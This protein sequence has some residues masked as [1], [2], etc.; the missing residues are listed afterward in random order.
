M[1][2]LI[3]VLAITGLF[4]A[5]VGGA[6][7]AKRVALVIGNGAYQHSPELVNPANDAKIMAG[8]LSKLGFD[9]V[10]ITDGDHKAILDGMSEFGRR[11][12]GADTALFFYAG[13]GLEVAGRNWL[14]PVDADIQASSDLPST[15]VK[16]DDVI[17]LMEL[18]DAR[19][20]LIVL[21]ACRN[22]PLPRSISRSAKR[23]LAK[24]DASAAGTM[25]VFSAA[26][27]EVALDGSGA[28][29]PFSTAL[30]KRIL[31]PGLE[32]RQMVGRVRQDVLAATGDKQVPWVNEAISG[33]FYLAGKPDLGTTDSNPSAPPVA[34]TPPQ[35]DP[36]TGELSVELAFWDSVK[37]SGNKDLI[38]LY[39]K[40]YPNGSFKDLAEVLI[41]SIDNANSTQRNT[42]T[43][44]PAAPPAPTPQVDQTAQMEQMSRQFVH[45]LNA[46]LSMPANQAVN[47][48]YSL[49]APNV[50][51]YGKQFS[52][53]GIVKDK[54]RLFTRWPNRY[55]NSANED[56]VVNCNS[57]ARYCDASSIVFWSVNNDQGGNG[58]GGQMEMQLRLDFSSGNPVIISEDAKTISAN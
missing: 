31:E 42:S 4:L 2:R 38:G 39:L 22:N 15:A 26:P 18:S 21:D 24:I 36:V 11:A 25:V 33:D 45:R 19:I 35:T 29:S 57:G 16:I 53:A 32:I 58:K 46:A 20:R 52:I 6:Q 28:N 56:I 14:L 34:Q 44:V 48:L 27:G 23:G 13:H 8:S 49:Y 10:S 37:N 3:A 17:E 9:V 1:A 55:Y 47:E 41:A 40:K 12:Q 51:F 50:N 30:A 43:T 5:L 54:S 7:A